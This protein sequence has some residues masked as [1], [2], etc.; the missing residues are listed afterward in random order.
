MEKTVTM[1]E[2]A[3]IRKEENFLVVKGP[4]GELRREFRHP[5]ISVKIENST[6]RMKSDTERKKVISV[7]GTW[8]AHLRNMACGVQSGWEARLKV[9]YSHFPIKV[10]IEGS[11]VLIQNF[12]GERKARTAK[13]FG[14]SKVEVK[15]DEIMV[16]GTDK[17]AVGHTCSNIELATKVRCRDKRIFQDGIYIT[18]KPKPVGEAK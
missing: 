12:E 8:A 17:E 7:V 1:P 3:S 14:D 15:K 11:K 2:G 16:T 4:K 6:V 9:V 18:S 5:R 13:I 10:G